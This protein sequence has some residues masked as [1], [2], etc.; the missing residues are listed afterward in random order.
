MDQIYLPVAKTVIRQHRIPLPRFFPDRNQL[1]QNHMCQKPG[2]AAKD[3]AMLLTGIPG[4]RISAR[5]AQ[6][7]A[8]PL[9]RIS[10]RK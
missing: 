3:R 10:S 1:D 2:G 6:G 7:G 8:M 5:G 9:T 4:R